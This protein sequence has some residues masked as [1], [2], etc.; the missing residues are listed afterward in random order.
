MKNI[1]QDL[2]VK[3]TNSSAFAWF[4][5]LLLALVWGSSFIL[6]KKSLLTFTAYEVGALRI[7]IS[8]IAFVPL[9]ISR[10][11]DIPWDKWLPLLVI[12]LAGSA[13]PAFLYPMAETQLSSSVVGVLNSMTPLFAVIFGVLFF[14][15]K[16][17]R[18]QFIGVLIGLSGAVLLILLNNSTES[19]TVNSYAL[20]VVLGTMLYAT[21]VNTVKKYFQDLNSTTLSAV[22][23]L[24]VGPPAIAYV[25]YCDSFSKVM[26]S[27]DGLLSLGAVLILSL[28]GTVAA[29]VLFYKMVQM[30][31]VAFSTSVAYLIPIIAILLGVLDDE[32][33]SWYIL[34]GMGLILTGV[35][36][37]RRG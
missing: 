23:F 19:T 8:F 22:A 29:T 5:L 6:I 9:L 7:A 32:P 14:G 13:I 36:F 12:G 4:L 17:V 10:R 26:V 25:L 20:L 33:F 28:A 35:Y 31:N 2:G 27:S 15:A 34:V 16:V 21:S 30:T 11:R 37:T 24:F 18:N 3:Q 1:E